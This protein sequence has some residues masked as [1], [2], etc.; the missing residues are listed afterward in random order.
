MLQIAIVGFVIIVM[1]LLFACFAV[2]SNA[3]DL[4]DEWYRQQ[5]EKEVEEK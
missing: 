5:E 4:T 1:I 2:S 3:D